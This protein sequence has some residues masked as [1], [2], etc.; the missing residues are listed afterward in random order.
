MELVI[1]RNDA[2]RVLVLLLPECTL[3]QR[4]AGHDC[5][6]VE[7]QL[8]LELLLAVETAVELICLPPRDNGIR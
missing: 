5:L 2:G 8:Q 6:A 7:Q 3:L 4:G 1:T